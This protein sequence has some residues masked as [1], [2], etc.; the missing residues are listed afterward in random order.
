MITTELG[1]E[2]SLY[3]LKEFE[4]ILDGEK[5]KYLP[6]KAAQYKILAGSTIAQIE[7]LKKEIADYERQYLK[8][9]S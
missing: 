1:Y 3:W 7:Q 6:Q 5:K 9:A 2:Q 8:K 4:A